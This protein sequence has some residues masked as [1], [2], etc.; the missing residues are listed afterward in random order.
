MYLCSLK[1]EELL[2]L[3]PRGGEIA[4]IGVAEG[5]FSREIL[6]R[7]SPDRLHLIDPWEHQTRGDYKNDIYGNVSTN[8]QNARLLGIKSAFAPHIASG[9][10]VLNQTYSI[11]AASEF[12]DE[13]LDWIYLDALHSHEAVSED[14]LAYKDKIKPDGFILGHD[15]TNHMPARNAGFGV[16]SAVNEFAL[17]HGY[18]FML[19]T[20]ENFPTYMLTKNPDSEVAKQLLLN[21]LY[22]ATTVVE[23]KNYPSNHAFEHHAVQIGDKQVVYCSY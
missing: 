4:E 9:K 13:Q 8:E 2:D 14:L 16:V 11:D 21:V 3:L 23:L 5:N 17:E 1:R 15:Y 10:V 19:S 7:V 6:A 12:E 22:R 18:A 20:M